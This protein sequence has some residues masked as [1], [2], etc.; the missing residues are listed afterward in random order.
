VRG[1]SSTRV[2]VA[3]LLGAPIQ[4]RTSATPTETGA[5][6]LAAWVA[7]LATSTADADLVDVAGFAVG[8]PG[9]VRS[10]ERSIWNAPNLPQVEDPA[11]LRHL[12]SRLERPVAVD[13]DSNY[14][15]LG[16]LR[17]GAAR[18]ASTAVM[19]TVGAGLGAGVALDGH[20][21]R[22]RNGLVGEFGQLPVGPMGT[23]LEQLVTGRGIT[24]RAAEL[25]HPVSSPAEIFATDAAPQLVA[26]RRHLEQ[27]LLVVLTTAVVS[28]EPDVVV[29]GGGIAGSLAPG[30]P[31]L[32][33]E[34]TR[35]VGCAP[36]VV[37][38]ELQDMSGA[39][40]AVVAALHGVYVELGL[41]P[42]DLTRVPRRR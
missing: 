13:N 1:A 42:E 33:A 34:L 40:G 2:V 32:T 15:L 30:L 29:I 7:E 16:E 10:T 19:L 26:L 22:G 6:E 36:P 24:R 8:V 35:V 11:F 9:A 39:F 20:L 38:A 28:Y 23:A 4:Q 25:G 21:L 27:A 17:F 12:E 14:A 5:E 41:A 3:D 31:Q 18:T 37:I